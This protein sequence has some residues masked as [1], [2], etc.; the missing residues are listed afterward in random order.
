M[1]ILEMR[2]RIASTNGNAASASIPQCAFRQPISRHNTRPRVENDPRWQAI[3]MIGQNTLLVAYAVD[4]EDE[5]LRI[6]SARKA[7]RAERR[8]YAED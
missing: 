6:I 5:V 2:T 4:E 1:P 7:T 3:G 8:I